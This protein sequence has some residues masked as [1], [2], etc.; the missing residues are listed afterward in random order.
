MDTRSSRFRPTTQEI[1][2]VTRTSS[3]PPPFGQA[4]GDAERALTGLLRQILDDDGGAGRDNWI[5]MQ[6]LVSHGGAMGQDQFAGEI[7]RAVET[8]PSTLLE[9]LRSS[10]VVA[11]VPRR[12]ELTP[13]GEALHGR[14][15]ESVQHAT[16]EVLRDFNPDE[17]ETAIR[18]LRGA[19][20]RAR[21]LQ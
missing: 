13:D 21:A 15:R 6:V 5:A 17:I 18:V 10:G 7:A 9:E 14:L 2:S 16:R 3:P 20:A 8:A 1:E 11:V 4:V 19:T 12:V